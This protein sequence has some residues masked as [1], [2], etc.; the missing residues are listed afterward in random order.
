MVFVCWCFC[1]KLLVKFTVYRK[2]LYIR[3]K[4]Q[5]KGNLFNIVYLCM[6]IIKYVDYFDAF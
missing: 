6:I 4:Y 1:F 2:V 5:K 3:E